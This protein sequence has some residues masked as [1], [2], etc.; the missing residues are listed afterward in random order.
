MTDIEHEILALL[1]ELDEL[2]R[3]MAVASLKPDLLPLFARLDELTLLLPHGTNADL[4]HCLHKKS[5][6]K[7]R[8]LLLGRAAENQ[9][10]TCHH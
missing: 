6:E 10:G 3:G 8:L 5:Y 2:V 9:P 1:G 4:L 7:A